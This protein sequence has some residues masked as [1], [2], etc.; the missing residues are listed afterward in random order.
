[1]ALEPVVKPIIGDNLPTKET[2]PLRFEKIDKIS[3]KGNYLLF[4]KD[5]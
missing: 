3:L 5:G 2:F 1:M 4:T